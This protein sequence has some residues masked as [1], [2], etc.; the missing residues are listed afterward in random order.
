M[1]QKQ[2]KRLLDDALR[3]EATRIL[4]NAPCSIEMPA[5]AGKTH[6]LAAAAALVVERGERVLILTHTN[7]G[8]DVLR[9]RL[10]KFNV[11]SSG[12]HVETITGWAFAMVKAYPVIAGMSVPEIPD[13]TESKSYIDGATRVARSN[14]MRLVNQAS[15]GYVFVDEYQDC[16]S[17]H[18]DFIL[19]IESSVNRVVV[20]GDR[21]QGIFGFSQPIVDWDSSV[22][23][24]F[25]PLKLDH[26]PHRWNGHNPELGS[27]LLEL[28]NTLV[29]GG[30][31]DLADHSIPG[32]KWIQTTAESL[33]EAAYSYEG[34][35][36][37]V[38]I[39]D[40]WPK[41][42]SM[43]ASMLGGGYLVIEDVAGRFMREQLSILPGEGEPALA[44]WLARFVK[45]CSVGLAS[46][47][48]T[49]LNRLDR[50][51]SILHY[52][53]PGVEAVV[54]ALDRL[55]Q[56]PRY[57]T[58]AEVATEIQG[59]SGIAVYRREAWYDTLEAIELTRNDGR[60]VLEHFG[61]VRDRLRQSGRRK[62]TRISSTTLLVKG[63]E[64]DHVIIPNLS[65]LIDP[66]HLY[67]ALSRARKSVIVMGRDARIDL[68]Q[69]D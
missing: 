59:V 63:L 62:H 12:F 58:L 23:T 29:D 37:T 32:L 51:A 18:H 41:G 39:V 1:R 13:W 24:H 40:K 69:S 7:A 22:A 27:W 42:A 10:R 3:A 60:P 43:H 25:T 5:G 30:E 67:V 65:N 57:V 8:V 15:F 17:S 20:V 4:E 56:D 9:R 46:I 2:A 68:V 31:F 45:A 19:S 28:R 34:F 35:D 54:S 53:R 36:D 16:N 47:D 49:V 38:L 55:R 14:V 26:F 64:Y 66:R 50:D 52:R 21:L 44:G 48:A 6:L 61:R 11:A 33:Y